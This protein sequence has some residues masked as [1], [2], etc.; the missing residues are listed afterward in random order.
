MNLCLLVNE[1]CDLVDEL[2]PVRFNL[3][4]SGSVSAWT[5]LSMK[6]AVG[7][8]ELIARPLLGTNQ[9]QDFPQELVLVSVVRAAIA[10][11]ADVCVRE[12]VLKENFNPSARVE[13]IFHCEL[14]V[15]VSRAVGDMPFVTST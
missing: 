15:V 1:G 8:V 7:E 2:L 5:H 13:S 4:G 9:F 6:H 12:Q 10:S 3:L 11:L 14:Q